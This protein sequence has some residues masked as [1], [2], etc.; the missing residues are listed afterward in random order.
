MM[1]TAQRRDK[2]LGGVVQVQG[3]DQ[4]ESDQQLHRPV[5]RGPA[6][7]GIDFLAFLQNLLVTGMLHLGFQHFNHRST[8]W[9]QFVARFFQLFGQIANC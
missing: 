4:P 3:A 5:Y 1:V 7:F 6:E 8:G 9:S 2:P